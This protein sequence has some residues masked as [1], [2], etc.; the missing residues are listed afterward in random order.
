M[1]RSSDGRDRLAMVGGAI[2]MNAG[3]SHGW[4]QDVLE[5]ISILTPAGVTQTVGKEQLDFTYRKLSLKNGVANHKPNSP[6]IIEGYFYLQPSDGL[7]LQQEAEA[8]LKKRRATQPTHLPSAG[9][10]FKNPASGKSAGELIDR[11]GLKGKKIGGALVS[12]KHANF[13]INSGD[14]SAGDILALMET[15]Q[16]AVLK[17]FNI[18]LEPEVK[19]V[20]R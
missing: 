4:I 10:F 12:P 13:I 15:V 6:I 19:I 3:T 5:E 14:A 8:I 1:T 9:C 7:Q 17:I 11:A 2:M 20:G 18:Q 16:A